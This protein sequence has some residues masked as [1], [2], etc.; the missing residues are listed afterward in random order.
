MGSAVAN[1]TLAM[2]AVPRRY[3]DDCGSVGTGKGCVRSRTLA[4]STDVGAGCRLAP[5]AHVE[6]IGI[7]QRPLYCR[8]DGR[9]HLAFGPAG[10]AAQTNAP[11]IVR[12]ASFSRCGLCG[13][14]LG[15]VVKPQ[16]RASRRHRR[17]VVSWML[18][19]APLFQRRNGGSGP[20]SSLHARCRW[21]CIRRI[22]RSQPAKA[23]NPIPSSGSHR[24]LDNCAGAT[25][26]PAR[27]CRSHSPSCRS[28]CAVDNCHVLANTCSR[29]GRRRVRKLTLLER[30]HPLSLFERVTSDTTIRVRKP[31]GMVTMPGWLKGTSALSAERP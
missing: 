5:C 20:Y 29:H 22:H 4:P 13:N 16:V 25:L 12:R 3:G 8:L 26:S 19:R 24:T 31:R 27:I 11:S 23:R 28:A 1:E 15:S 17:G 2:V 6:S 14:Y 18:H 9:S 30:P 10:P 21:L 7:A